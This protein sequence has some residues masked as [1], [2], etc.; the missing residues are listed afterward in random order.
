MLNIGGG[1]CRGSE[2]GTGAKRMPL[3]PS[4]IGGMAIFS[5]A[6]A[7]TGF[8][9]AASIAAS[10]VLHITTH[11]RARSKRFSKRY[12]SGQRGLTRACLS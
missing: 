4:C 12:R 10:P 5:S 2:N 6:S 9:R 7:A 11:T 8:D 3:R 1:K